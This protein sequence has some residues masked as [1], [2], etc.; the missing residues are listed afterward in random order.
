MLVRFWLDPEWN[1]V[2]SKTWTGS[3]LNENRN[4]I[5]SSLQP[6]PVQ[7][8][9]VL[10]TSWSSSG[11]L[12]NLIVVRATHFRSSSDPD[13]VQVL[14]GTWIISGLSKTW[15]WSGRVLNLLEMR[16]AVKLC[17]NSATLYALRGTVQRL[18]SDER[19]KRPLWKLQVTPHHRNPNFKR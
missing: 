13:S 6:D 19:Q 4:N 11:L 12:K 7:P 9:Q 3:G 18:Y 2:R 17:T 10:N 1:E 16:F 5:R 15:S 14:K 8:V